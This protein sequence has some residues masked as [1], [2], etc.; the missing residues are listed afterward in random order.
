MSNILKITKGIG[1][2]RSFDLSIIVLY[3]KKI[4]FSTFL[5]IKFR[6][7]IAN[8]GARSDQNIAQ[9]SLKYPHALL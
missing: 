7:N 5:I 9:I 8:C 4:F 6:I 2:V 1:Y 3:D